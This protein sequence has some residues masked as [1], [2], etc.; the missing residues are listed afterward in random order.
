LGIDPPPLLELGRSFMTPVFAV[1][2]F[3]SFKGTEAALHL[4][5]G[6]AARRTIIYVIT[7]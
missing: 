1:R 3:A 5:S 4:S 6:Y 7:P 2:R